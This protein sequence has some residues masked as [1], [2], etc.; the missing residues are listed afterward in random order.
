MRPTIVLYKYF[1][2]KRQK[3]HEIH[4]HFG[5]SV[6][7]YQRIWRRHTPYAGYRVLHR[8]AV[9]RCKGKPRCAPYAQTAQNAQ[10]AFKALHAA[11]LLASA[12]Q[13]SG[14]VS[15]DNQL[16]LETKKEER[17]RKIH[18]FRQLLYNAETDINYVSKRVMRRN[19]A[20]YLLLIVELKKNGFNEQ[21]TDNSA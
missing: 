9:S 13:P 4:N 5:S 14:R 8:A 3:N 17:C 10:P 7:A 6:H 11:T 2:S 21:C 12:A 20:Q 15:L 19:T 16:A 18:V 1:N